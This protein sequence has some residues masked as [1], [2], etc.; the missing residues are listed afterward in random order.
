MDQ[1]NVVVGRHVLLGIVQKPFAQAF[2][3]F[4]LDGKAGCHRMAAKLDEQV[5]RRLQGFVHIEAADTPA[6]ALADA[7]ADGN[8]Q[9]R[10]VVFF[11]EARCGNADDADVPAFMTG[12][13][14]AV[15][16]LLPAFDLG[17]GLFG[18][19]VLNVLTLGVEF[20]ELRG[21]SCRFFVVRL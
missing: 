7:V 12:N 1:G 16:S 15:P 11:D 10:A 18:N 5:F 17:D 21:R 20:T 8:D 9:G 14:D 2:D 19:G 3:V 13:E 4:G 6:R